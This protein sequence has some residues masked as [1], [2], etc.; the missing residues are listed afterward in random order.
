LSSC[1]ILYL[2]RS[3]PFCI[4]LQSDHCRWMCVLWRE[5]E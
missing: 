3:A 2:P 5:K 1:E 4:C